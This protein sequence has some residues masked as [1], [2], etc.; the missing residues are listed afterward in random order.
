MKKNIK[1]QQ[2]KRKKEFETLVL[3]KQKINWLPM[4]ALF[5]FT[6]ILYGNTLNHNFVIDDA[7]VF[8]NHPGVQKGIAGIPQI[9]SDSKVWGYSKG[10]TYR[11]I[12]LISFAIEKSLFDNNPTPSHF[13]NVLFYAFS[14]LILYF[15]LNQW[16]L[17]YFKEKKINKWGIPFV[18]S[19]LFLAHP[20][21][22]EVVANIKSRDE[23]FVL[24]FGLLSLFALWKYLHKK[25]LKWIILSLFA[26]LFCVFSKESGITILGIFPLALFYFSEINIKKNLLQTLPY[27]GI[28]LLFLLI[29]NQIIDTHK[30]G[31]LS[32]KIAFENNSI[33]AAESFSN[34]LATTFAILGKYLLLLI[35][36]HP[37]SWDYSFAQIPIYRWANWQSVISFLV[38][39]GLFVFAIFTLKKKNIFAFGIL[40]FLITFSLS[41][42]LFI[43]IGATL[44]ERFLFIPSLGF[45]ICLVY[46]L[47]KLFK[48]KDYNFHTNKITLSIL[49]IILLLFSIKTI[50]RNS[51]WKNNLS[52]FKAGVESSSN[53]FRT[54]F[55]LAAEYAT[56]SETTPD[57]NTY[58]KL[59]KK[60][61]E[62]LEK[63]ASINPKS[64]VYFALGEMYDKIDSSEKALEANLKFLEFNPKDTASVNKIG[65]HYYKKEDYETASKFFEQQ[66]KID[67][68]DKEGHFNLG[69]AYKE[70]GKQSEA[71]QSFFKALTIDTTLSMGYYFIG[72]LFYQQNQFHKAIPFLERYR[73]DYP[74]DPKIPPKLMKAYLAIGNLEKSSFYFQLYNPPNQ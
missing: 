42:N 39:W 22:T 62:H 51:D 10:A 65:V 2:K 14:I 41:N 3:E 35:F 57:S 6:F 43:K 27:L 24:F 20:I 54:H 63:T 50:S 49:S 40:F 11:P 13:L 12:T 64:S 36:P 25:R 46:L 17:F 21:H 31:E 4:I 52:I 55:A 23:I 18:I 28:V 16:F 33:L 47:Y 58:H 70:I 8:T 72:D 9:L 30:I 66:V 7:S 53:S 29:R 68:T 59:L 45:C 32:H 37:L 1:K 15:L 34:Q 44:G 61:I 26:F 19:L 48:I 74:K 60:S 69:M 73:K 67:S 38:Y 71:I 5:I 56:I